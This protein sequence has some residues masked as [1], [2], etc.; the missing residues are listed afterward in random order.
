[1]AQNQAAYLDKTG[2]PLRVASA[3]MPEPE[4]NDLVIRNGSIAINPVDWKIQDL[5]F[6]VQNWPV[7]LGSDVAG[8]VVSVG[9]EVKDF[10]KGDRVAACVSPRLQ[11]MKEYDLRFSCVLI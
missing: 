1:M 6:Y 5:G 2:S 8:E 7:V 10:K 4:A 9:S 11:L 3:P